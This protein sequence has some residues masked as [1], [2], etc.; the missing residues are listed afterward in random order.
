MQLVEGVEA[1]DEYLTDHEI[2]CAKLKQG[3]LKLTKARLRL[4][5]HALSEISYREE[6][7]ASRVV[8]LDS[9]GNWR[10]RDANATEGEKETSLR[11]RK[12]KEEQQPESK[13]SNADT[14]LWFSSLPPS[15]LR[16]AQKQF[17]SG[18]VALLVA[19]ATAQKVQEAVH[20]VNEAS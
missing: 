14:L 10:L 18:L 3:F 12:G 4:P 6:F 20:K 13:D 5:P 17:A 7:E 16:Q 1:L 15:D 2:A 9:D 11:R 8:E 19:A